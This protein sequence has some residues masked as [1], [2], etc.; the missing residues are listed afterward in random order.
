LTLRSLISS[1]F[2]N[3]AVDNNMSLGLM[4]DL[5]NRYHAFSTSGLATYTLPTSPANGTSAGAVET[6]DEPQ[7]QQLITRFLGSAPLPIKTPALD[8]SGEPEG[9]SA[10]PS[11]TQ[12]AEAI[13]AGIGTAAPSQAATAPA[14]DQV[15]PA[16]YDPTPC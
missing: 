1:T 14:V 8:A 13:N 16:R 12:P 2:K 4:Y 9:V 10:V 5:A 3:I 15:A 11:N 7:A 6:V